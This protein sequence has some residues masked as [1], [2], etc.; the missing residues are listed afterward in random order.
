MLLPAPALAQGNSH[1]LAYEHFAAAFADTCYWDEEARAAHPPQS[2]QL[3]WQPEYAEITETA[4]LYRFFC[5]SG[6]Y[7]VNHV[8]FI[9]TEFGGLQPVGF[10]TPSFDIVYEN[11]D[12]EGDVIDITITGYTSQ[13]LLTNSEFD[14]ESQTIVSHALWRGL[15]D[16]FSTG[17]WRFSE[18]QFVLTRYDVDAQYDGE[19]DPQT[20]SA[21][22]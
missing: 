7:N 10:A 15:G 4:T 18:G 2:W 22:D 6:A 20:L 3:S 21:F 1:K 14:P 11:D 19:A 9:E 17:T 12:F 16:A 8:Y 5:D 13:L